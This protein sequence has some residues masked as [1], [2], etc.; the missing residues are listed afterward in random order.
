MNTHLNDLRRVIRCQNSS[1]SWRLI[2]PMIAAT[3][4]MAFFSTVHAAGGGGGPPPTPTGLNGPSTDNDGTYTVSWNTVPGTTYYDLQ[5]KIGA[6]A[7]YTT[8]SSG[9]TS[10]VFSTRPPNTYSYR[11]RACHYL[12]GCSNY[13]GSIAVVVVAPPPT[14]T[15]LTGPAIDNDGS[16]TI[17]WNA[18]S[19]ATSYTLEEKKNSGAWVAKYTG[20]SPSKAI[21]GNNNGAYAY[22]VKACNASPNCSAWSSTHTTTVSLPPA[23]PPIPTGLT[24]P[25]HDT[26]GSYTISWNA[27]S[28]AVSYTLEQKLNSG[29]W[30]VKYSGA[31]LSKAVSGNGN[32]AYSYRVKACNVTPACSG[33]SATHATT[34]ELPPT[35][36]TGLTS[37]GTDYDGSYTVSWNAASG[38]SSYTLEQRL[39]GGAWAVK[40]S[41]ASTSVGISGNGNGTYTYRVRGCNASC[42]GW[43]STS[44]TVVEPPPPDPPPVPGGLLGPATDIDGEYSIS[45][46]SAPRATY[47]DLQEKIGTG[48]WYTTYSSG[49]TSVVFSK[50]SISTYSYR[51]RACHY[52]DGCS[53]YSS[54]ITVNVTGGI[55]S[56]VA[57]G[58]VGA[59]GSTPYGIDVA[60]DGDATISLP[61]QFI[62]G[63]AGF[64]PSLSLEYNSGR[65]VDRLERS[66]PEDTLGYGWRLAGLSQIRRCVVDQVSTASIA[67]TNND[68]LCLDG[69]PLVLASGT[70]LTTGATYRTLIE[71]YIK[72]EVKN[73]GSQLWFEATLPDGTVREY[74][75]DITGNGSRVNQNYGVDYQ[76]SISKA[77]SVD[78]NVVNYRYWFDPSKGINYINSIE[79]TDA[80][81]DFEYLTR[82]D[83]SAVS[84]GSASQTQSVFLHTIRVKY[85]GKKVREYRLL[86]EVVSSRRRLNKVQLCGYNEAGTTATCLAP[87]DFDWLT[88]GSTMSGV[89]ILVD[90]MTDGLSAVHLIEYGTITGSSHPF[91]FTERPFGNGSSPANTQ[92]LSGSGALRHAAI[93]LRRDNGLGGFHDTTYAYQ[94]KGLK[95]T[96]H[97]GFLGFYAQRMKDEQ[98]G[99]VTY[100]QYRMDYPYFG[101][102]ARLHQLNNTYGSHTQTLTRSETDFAQQSISHGTNSSV[103]PYRSTTVDFVYEGATQLGASKT[104][105]ALTFASGF[106]SQIVSTSQTGTGVSTGSAGGS[107]GDIPTYTLSSLKN[108]TKVTTTFTNRTTSGKWLINFAD[109]VTKESWPGAVSGPGIVQDTTLIPHTNSLR[110][111]WINKFPLDADLA[112]ATAFGYDIKGRSNGTTVGGAN[113]PNRVTGISGY[114]HDRYPGVVTNP[115]GHTTTYSDY[116]LRFGLVKLTGDPNGRNTSWVRDPFGRVTSTENGDGVITTTTYTDCPTGCGITVYGIAPTYKVS[117]DSIVTPIRIAPI[118]N[119]YFDNLGRVIRTET[120]SFYGTSYSK[121]DIKY[122]TQG[123]VQKSSLPYFSGTSKDVIPTYDIRNRITNVTRPDG[124]STGT[125]YSVS[126][127]K[128]VATITENV[129]K[130]NGTSDGTQVKRNEY[131][132]LGELTKTTDGYG[133][134]VNPNTAYTYDA[135]GNMLTAVVNGGAAGSTTTTFEYDAAGNQEKIIGPDIGTVVSTYT[136]I[137]EVKTRTDNLSQLSTYTYDELGRL[138]TLVNTDGTST[139]VWDIATNGKGKLYTRSNSGFTETFFYDTAGR[140]ARANTDITPI[141]GSGSTRHSTTHTYDTYGRLATTTYPGGFV[142]TRVYNAQGYLSQLKDGATVLQTFNGRDAFGNSTDESYANGVDTLRTFDPETGGLTDINTT[143]SSTVFQNNDYAWRSNSTLE[144]R[145]ANPAY[146]LGSTR[147]ESYTYDVLNR[148]TVAETYINSSNTRDL[149]Y[150]YNQLGNV[151]SKVSTLTGDT[152]VT[153]YAYG[154]GLA[155][156]HAATGFS[157]DG[158]ARTLFYD[159]NGAVTKYDIAGTSDDKYIAYNAS[160]QPAKITI[161]DSLDDTT[162]VARDEF[163]YDPN[164]QRYARKTSWQDGGST[165]TEEVSYIGVSEVIADST[166]SQIVTKTRVSANVMHVK[167]VGPSRTEEFFEYAHRDHLGSIEVVTDENG[168]KLD[169]LAFEP[170]GS[171]KKKDWTANISTAELD[172]LLDLDWDHPRKARGF[173]GHEHLDRTGFVHMNGRVYDPV[174]G[175]FLSPDPLVS[176]PTLAQSWNRYSYVLNNPLGLVDP[177]GFSP[178]GCGLDCGSR[179]WG[180][181]LNYLGF[182]DVFG[183]YSDQNPGFI[184]ACDLEPQGCGPRDPFENEVSQTG[185]RIYSF[186]VGVDSTVGGN[187][188]PIGGPFTGGGTS[189]G[190]NSAGQAYLKFSSK[191]EAGL[192]AFFGVSAV[193]SLGSSQGPLQTGVSTQDSVIVEANAGWGPNAVGGSVTTDGSGLSVTRSLRYGVGYGGALS[194]GIQRDVYIAT[195]PLAPYA[196]RGA[197]YYAT[198]VNAGARAVTDYSLQFSGQ[199]VEVSNTVLGWFSPSN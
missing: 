199:L 149:S 19:T 34:V 128:A 134:S 60:T 2:A 137:G 172:V 97:W 55:V 122:D 195:P 180:F 161:G 178:D 41:G 92:L 73:I 171:R 150:A 80:V 179:S 22:R 163:A 39:G 114:V 156:P 129:K 78:G 170:F 93:K 190:F 51:V 99:I 159:L 182:I 169:N 54:S 123:R 26:D 64:A 130:A 25:S 88:P 11:V 46:N 105:N 144:S 167:I 42:S 151:T 181:R 90:G 108:T 3:M 104:S 67:L 38:A 107:W 146:G 77:T 141:G 152:D 53:N 52:L 40:Y 28:A 154:A 185:G 82:T 153:G 72:I 1:E 140:S 139:W 33:W 6:G 196:A 14:P 4:L 65:G 10:V 168:N 143:K 86:D 61:L 121:R 189:A 63:V 45:W 109:A 69:M 21:S 71:S 115:K 20:S 84:I 81:V 101:E 112:I 175:R 17:S 30:T 12:D 98:S 91:L 142:V 62:P 50:W 44:A 191:V 47:Y 145:V 59:V 96:K 23:V 87:L 173:T 75:N 89:P 37:P 70:H 29:A 177:T 13:S 58:T 116:D 162:P 187:P 79:Y 138:K 36:P 100:A 76:W 192:W 18:A 24:G 136:G 132:I 127:G 193:G 35:T 56:P 164:G 7:W 95:S 103:Y 111:M 165:I 74:A 198:G 48:A 15:G 31:S 49:P 184:P 8:Y 176:L 158:V 68:S 124:S 102:V 66:L 131:S 126:S 148:V 155:G 57:E 183:R 120:Q 186:S 85:D 106:V 133:T 110:A 194:G 147:K 188:V 113:V 83:A 119:T 135:N 174:S 117:A 160:N 157:V 32:G 197:D 5:E 166:N 9:P 125:V 43:S 16:Y 27:A 118:R 94:N